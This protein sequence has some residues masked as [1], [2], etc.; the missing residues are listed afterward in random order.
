[1]NVVVPQQTK[2]Q[3]PVSEIRRTPDLKYR[4]G[5]YSFEWPMM[6]DQYFK[7]SGEMWQLFLR[8]IKFGGEKWAANHAF[9]SYQ[10]RFL[11]KNP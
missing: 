4:V 8:R 1:M 7:P 5:T 3:L 9:T 11:K 6:K 10:D 2:L